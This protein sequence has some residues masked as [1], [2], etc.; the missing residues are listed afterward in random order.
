M[1]TSP[2]VAA[3][4]AQGA[5]LTTAALALAALASFALAGCAPPPAKP[6]TASAAAADGC[7]LTHRTSAAFT[8]PD[9]ADIVETRSIG[10][11]CADAVVVI[12]VRKATG[13]PLWAW[14]SPHPWL[15]PSAGEGAPEAAAMDAF[16]TGWRAKVDTTAGLPDWPERDVFR[17]S[18]GA[19]MHTPFERDQYLDIRAKALPRLCHAT[20]VESGVCIYYDP[21]SGSVSEVFQSGA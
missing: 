14:A 10:A 12:T 11:S 2:P 17:D 15:G 13:E 4:P 3:R 6:A 9:A 18:L 16:L 5:I 8:A 20:G 7:N 19:F 1:P 21:A